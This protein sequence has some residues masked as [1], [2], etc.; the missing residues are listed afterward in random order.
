MATLSQLIDRVA[1][2]LSMVSGTGVQIY[3]ED[4]IAEMIQH[5]F[6]VLFDEEFWPQFTTWSTF[7][8]DE[9]LG[10]ITTDVTELI[11]HVDDIQVIFPEGSEK[12]LTK[13]SGLTRNPNLLSGTQPLH[14]EAL[15]NAN[16]L[17]TSRV[18]NVWPKTATGNINV[19]YSTKPDNFVATDTID[20]DE[21]ALILGATYDY[22]ED[23]GTNPNA[24]QKFQAMFESRVTQLKDGHNSAPISLDHNQDTQ[25]HF[26]FSIA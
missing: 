23:D 3:A 22:L 10:L 26:G 7:T 15:S 4:R 24:T 8:L 19:R 14:Y 20:F 6:D 1:N 21:Q 12:A 16:P 25:Y 9:T 11:K 2:R 13:L 17:R 5:K 18:F